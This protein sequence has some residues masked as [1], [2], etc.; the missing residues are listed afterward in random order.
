MATSSYFRAKSSGPLNDRQ[1][2]ILWRHAIQR[3][4]STTLYP[5]FSELSRPRN[6][7]DENA[8]RDR[9]CESPAFPKSAACGRIAFRKRGLALYFLANDKLPE[10]PST[11]P[12]C[13]AS[14][15]IFWR[16]LP[17]SRPAEGRSGCTPSLTCG[18]AECQQ[19]RA[20]RTASAEH[21]SPNSVKVSVSDTGPGI[22]PEYHIEVFDDFFRLPESEISRRHGFRTR[23]RAPPGNGMGGKI[24]VE[25][26]PGVGCKIFLPPSPQTALQ[27]ASK[28][29]NK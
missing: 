24:W 26:E 4:A 7:R 8:V 11:R 2:E 19:P 25:S 9:E 17:S 6:R 29:K 10:F 23:H 20:R 13:S 1:R 22:P 28:G 21:R 18:S 14:S 5:G 15:P 27:L 12:N 16:T 3:P